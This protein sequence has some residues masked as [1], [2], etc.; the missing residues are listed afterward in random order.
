M[1]ASAVESL[2]AEAIDRIADSSSGADDD[3]VRKEAE[4]GT[5]KTGTEFPF[6]LLAREIRK[7]CGWIVPYRHS[8]SRVQT[9]AV[10]LKGA[11]L[12]GGGKQ[13]T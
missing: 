8:P 1:L 11:V 2:P 10:D 9:G 3:S 6:L 12:L 7:N 4:P 13:L 5:E